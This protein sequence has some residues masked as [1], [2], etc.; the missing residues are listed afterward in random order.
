L[1]FFA[2]TFSNKAD[3]TQS[4]EVPRM[5]KWRI[6]LWIALYI[7]LLAVIGVVKTGLK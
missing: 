6:V 4:F 7:A 1:T 2:S 3:V 5:G